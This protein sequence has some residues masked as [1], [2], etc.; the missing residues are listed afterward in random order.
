MVQVGTFSK[1]FGDE[2]GIRS[3]AMD[4]EGALL[5]LMNTTPDGDFQTYKAEDG[6][7]VR[8]NFFGRD[9]RT[10]AMV[11]GWSDDQVWKFKTRW[12]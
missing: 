10:A 1:L 4:R 5:D 8:A 11:A 7:F 6:A 2:S 3:F 12:P 9:P